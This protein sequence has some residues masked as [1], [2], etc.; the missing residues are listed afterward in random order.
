MKTTKRT[1]AWLLIL[2]M[3]LGLFT[4][5]ASGTETPA[6][7]SDPAAAA[8][9]P[10]AEPAAEAENTSDAVVK[11][12]TGVNYVERTG[13]GFS[14]DTGAALRRNDLIETKASSSAELALGGTTLALTEKTEIKLVSPAENAEIELSMGELFLRN[15]PGA[16]S[17][18]TFFDRTVT[19]SG[20]ALVWV[21]TG[22][23]GIL[24]LGGTAEADGET[25]SA[26]DSVSYTETS[27][28][29]SQPQATSLDEFA[30]TCAAAAAADGETLCYSAGDLN[31]VVEARAE[32]RRLAVEAQNAHNAAVLA[33][34]YDENAD[35]ASYSGP[36]CTIEIRCDTILDN[37][38]NLTDGKNAYVPANGTIL[39]TSQVSFSEG[40]TVFNVL[41]R[42]CAAAGIALEYSWTPM[43]GSYYIEGINNL[44][45]F[46]CGEQSGWMYKVNGWFPNYGCSSYTLKDGDIIVWCYTCNGLGA[47]V[48]GSVY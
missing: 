35:E 34:G 16:V 41:Q 45:E 24:V 6:S 39:A 1:A 19:L 40:E 30:L 32:E 12:T 4:G 29:R 46:D 31:A 8:D 25:L 48:G 7:A 28:D 2:V 5:C 11:G 38:E 17:T 26:G 15:A 43:Y 22:S 33:E 23:A 36:I 21:R 42:A 10:A 27:V 3:L 20:T 37:M 44:Y 13:I 14:L 18:L 47:D 9:E